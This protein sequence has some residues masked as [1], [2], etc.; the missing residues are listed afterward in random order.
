MAQPLV[1]VGAHVRLFVNGTVYSVAQSVS[2]SVSTGEYAIYGIDSPYAQELAGGGQISVRG[3]VRGVRIKNGGG[4]QA[5]NG[6]PLFSDVAASN[7][8][9]LRLEDRRTG[10]VI[11]SIPAA[12]ITELKDSVSVKGTYKADFDFIGQIAYLPL[13]LS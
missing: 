12:K 6:R 3:S 1:M 13:D 8:I 5:Q 7:Y 11:W 9:S 4:I 2:L 10:E